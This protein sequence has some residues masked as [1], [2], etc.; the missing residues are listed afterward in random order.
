MSTHAYRTLLRAISGLNPGDAMTIDLIR[1]ELDAADLSSA[2][3]SGAFRSACHEGY[4][5]GVFL[6]LPGL[7]VDHPVHAAIPSTHRSGKGRY[8]KVWRRTDQPMPEHVCEVAS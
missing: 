2:E 1:D 5:T 3:K 4:L 7:S 8:V 6:T